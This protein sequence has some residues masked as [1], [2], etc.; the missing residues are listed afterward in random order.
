MSQSKILVACV[1]NIFLGDDG[2]GVEVARRL[3]GR[4]WPD[5]VTVVDFGTRSF[6]L[7]FAL[8]DG[9]QAAILVD[10][11]SRGEAPGTL[12]VLE[13]DIDD[14]GEIAPASM[15]GHGLHPAQVLNLARF[16]GSLP[17]RVLV[18]GCEPAALGFGL[19]FDAD[20]GVGL[21]E[22]V[23]AAVDGA[24]TLVESLVARLA[25]EA[26]VPLRT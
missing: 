9:Y 2:F 20:G 17:E 26:A 5:R 1:G 22:P 8:L 24:V 7:A 25:A 10:A 23:Q 6:D 21:S 18:V 4:T 15:E 19:D 11:L 16:Y 14:L 13:P 3:A 12:Y